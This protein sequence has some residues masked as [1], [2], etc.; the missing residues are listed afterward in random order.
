MRK[1]TAYLI[2]FFVNIV[3]KG[4]VFMFIWNWHLSCFAAINF[5]QSVAIVILISMFSISEI[6]KE[7]DYDH[8]LMIAIETGITLFL[9]LIAFFLKY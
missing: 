7:S 3:F 9:F 1:I 5:Q 2:L 8:L 6:K 4:T